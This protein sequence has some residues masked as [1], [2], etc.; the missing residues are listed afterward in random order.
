LLIMWYLSVL[1]N[2]STPLHP[3]STPREK[4]EYQTNLIIISK[5]M[6]LYAFLNHILHSTVAKSN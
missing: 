3:K 5:L 2:T 4:K 1:V 6:Y